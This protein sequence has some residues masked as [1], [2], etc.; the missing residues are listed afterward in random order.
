VALAAGWRGSG[1]IPAEAAA[2]PVGEGPGR[3]PSSP[4]SGC[5]LEFGRGNRRQAALRRLAA[6]AAVSSATARQRRNCELAVHEQ[7][8]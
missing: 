7:L 8:P 5:G 1:G 2:R 4:R 6:V 3:S